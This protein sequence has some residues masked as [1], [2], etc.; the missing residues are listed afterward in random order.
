[1]KRAN[2]ESIW[3]IQG[4]NKNPRA[5]LL[6]GVPRGDIVVLDL[7]S[8]IKPN[9]GDPDLPSPYKREGGYMPHDWMFC[10]LL[11]FG[12]NVGLH[13]RMDNVIG[14]YYKTRQCSDLR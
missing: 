9:W 7:A 5:E 1:M 3:V 4:W 6:A 14:G 12:G 10:M 13:G 2:P 11:N 8:E